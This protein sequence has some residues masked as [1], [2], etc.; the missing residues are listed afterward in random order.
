MASPKDLA[1]ELGGPKPYEEVK[2]RQFSVVGQFEKLRLGT[3][4]GCEQGGWFDK[5]LNGARMGGW[6]STDRMVPPCC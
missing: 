1:R 4:L 5:N 3:D 6:L 2:D